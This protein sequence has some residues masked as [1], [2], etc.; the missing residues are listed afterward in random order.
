[1]RLQVRTSAAPPPSN[2]APFLPPTSTRQLHCCFPLRGPSVSHWQ[3]QWPNHRFW[4]SVR[5]TTCSPM[6]N[7]YT[8]LRSS[9]GK[10]AKNSDWPCA[11]VRASSPALGSKVVVEPSLDLRGRIV[12]AGS[13]A[14]DFNEKGIRDLGLEDDDE[15]S[16]DT[17][18][19]GLQ[20]MPGMRACRVALSF[21][22]SRGGVVA[23]GCDGEGVPRL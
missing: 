22:V 16:G 10:R 19:C 2:R 13:G 21:M 17:R 18:S 14:D 6:T 23:C 11:S 4:L 1:M 12:V 3:M 7:S 5:C 8:I 20:W 15:G 9:I